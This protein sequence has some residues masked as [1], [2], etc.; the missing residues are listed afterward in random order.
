MFAT[1]NASKGNAISRMGQVVG[2]EPSGR[3]VE[4][5]R[6]TLHRAIDAAHRVG[7][8][9]DETGD[10]LN[11]MADLAEQ[12]ATRLCGSYPTEGP[13]K[14]ARGGSSERGPMST[15]EAVNSA[16]DSL[17][18]RISSF[19]SPMSRIVRAIEMIEQANG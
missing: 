16:V 15:V 12:L 7:N 8:R 19:E 14:D 6:P 2:A 4:A 13:S 3:E 5:P 9:L 18:P 17:H 1:E 11:A 10:R